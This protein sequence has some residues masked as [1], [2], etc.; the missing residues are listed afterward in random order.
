M[1]LIFSSIAVVLFLVSEKPIR[2]PET[3]F[4]VEMPIRVEMGEFREVTREEQLK[5]GKLIALTFD[6]G[7]SE[8]TAKLL[9]VLRV[10]NVPAT[11]FALGSRANA[12][13][14]L[15]KR[16]ADEGH[17]VESHTMNHKNLT[18]LGVEGARAEIAGAEQAICTSRG[19]GD[20]CV[21]FV[22]PPYGEI[23]NT[24]RN[25][26]GKPMIGWSIDTE[27]WKS[28]NP[29]EM[30]LR[31]IIK[32][33]DGAVILMHDVYDT[34]VTGAEKI[35]DALKNEGYTF[36]TVEEMVQ[37]KGVSLPAGSYYGRFD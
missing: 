19:V 34:S 23:N 12:F 6:D 24:V 8:H 5:N 26:V 16:E 30:L 33:S 3:I 14:E 35:I 13:P 4:E 10:K 28:K 7:P 21:K 22:R 11:F 2:K 32:A 18:T 29:D 25:V 27:D 15:I 31:T 1:L 37:E 36:V 20:G 9:D 17:E